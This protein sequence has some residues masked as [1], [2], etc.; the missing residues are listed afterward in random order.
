MEIVEVSAKTGEGM[1]RWVQAGSAPQLETA[2][3]GKKDR[4]SRVFRLAPPT[5]RH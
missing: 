5:A 3:C 1:E 2:R 4:I